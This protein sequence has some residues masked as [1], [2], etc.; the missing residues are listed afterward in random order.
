MIRIYLADVRRDNRDLADE[1]EQRYG[2]R[3]AN[4]CRGGRCTPTGV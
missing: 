2:R 1:L 3:L 4:D